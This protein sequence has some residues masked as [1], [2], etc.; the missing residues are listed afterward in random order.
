MW[1]TGLFYKL[2]K[3]GVP[4]YL[5][6]IIIDFLSERTFVVECEGGLSTIKKIECGVPQGGVLSPTLF[7]LYINDVPI[8][9]NDE[10]ETLLFADDIVYVLSYAYKKGKIFS[11]AK[12]IC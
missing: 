11:K 1:Y 10:E 2:L 3:I 8:A 5:L 6:A 9:S 4:Y 7:S 12:I